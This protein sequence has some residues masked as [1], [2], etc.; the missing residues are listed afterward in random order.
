MPSEP[1]ANGVEG[2][3]SGQRPDWYVPIMPVEDDGR[4][5]REVLLDTFGADPPELPNDLRDELVAYLDQFRV[6]RGA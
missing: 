1:T 3:D 4:T 5:V 2:R 6:P